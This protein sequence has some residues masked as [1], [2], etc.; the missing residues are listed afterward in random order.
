[1]FVGSIAMAS[2]LAMVP[3]STVISDR[4]G[5]YFIPI[6]GVIFSRVPYLK[7]VRA[8]TYY[9]F[10]IYGGLG[11]LLLYWTQMSAIFAQCYIPYQSWIFGMPTFM[12]Y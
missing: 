2:L 6:Q 10:A 12:K 4:I 1:M 8:Q 5:Y 9:Q 7:L 11:M 3:F